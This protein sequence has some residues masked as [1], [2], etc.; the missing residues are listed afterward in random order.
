M[1]PLFLM[2]LITA[3]LA[4]CVGTLLIYIRNPRRSYSTSYLVLMGIGL[5]FL[6][7]FPAGLLQAYHYIGIVQNK[8][9]LLRLV[10]PV[11]AAPFNMGGVTVSSLY[12][13]IIGPPAPA[14]T[15]IGSGVFS[16]FHLYLPFLLAQ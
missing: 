10:I 7:S 8:P 15:G 14:K 11:L 5:Q 16:T 12:E 6:L 4:A 2:L 1:L 13:T 3:L 9:L